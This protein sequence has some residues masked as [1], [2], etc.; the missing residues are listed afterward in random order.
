M[1]IELQGIWNYG[2]IINFAFDASLVKPDIGLENRPDSSE[3]HLVGKFNMLL[4]W[5]LVAVHGGVNQKLVVSSGGRKKVTLIPLF[6][7]QIRSSINSL[8]PSNVQDLVQRWLVAWWHQAIYHLGGH[9]AFTI[10]K[11]DRNGQDICPDMN[12]KITNLMLQLHFPGVNHV[13]P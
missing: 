10:G 2:I 9:M 7:A 4:Q 5:H 6:S 12:L 8:W 13:N 11:F 1:K 3:W